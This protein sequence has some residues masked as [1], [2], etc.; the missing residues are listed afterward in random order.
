MKF[1][2]KP[3]IIEAMQWLGFSDGPHDL[4]IV[5]HRDRSR[6]GWID[7]LE[8]G[9]AVTPGDW[10]ITGVKGEK[11][12]CKPD[13]FEATYERDEMKTSVRIGQLWRDRDERCVHR[14]LKVIGID[15][16]WAICKRGNRTTSILIRRMKP[17]ARGY[18]RIK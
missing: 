17:G 14:T 4:G 2:K 18:E 10:I 15:G 13:I 8:G 16:D 3:V 1:R 6:N 5:P 7:T 11:Y 9:H 12:P